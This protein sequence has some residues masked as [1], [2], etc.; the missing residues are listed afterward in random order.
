MSS[1]VVF[2]I[3]DVNDVHKLSKFLHH[4]SVLEAMQK[5]KGRMQVCI[6]SYKGMLEQSFIMHEEDFHH[7]S[8]YVKNQ[9]S[10]LYLSDGH[11]GVV[12][13]ELRYSNGETVQLGQVKAVSKD[14]AMQHDAWTYRPDMN[15][16]WVAV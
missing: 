6:G 4:V 15:I 3:D 7:V 13:A 10:F 16:Y 12:Y 1:Y 5:T 14:E 8:A 2:S 9:E 11:K